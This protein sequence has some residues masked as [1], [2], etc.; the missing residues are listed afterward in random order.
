MT[1]PIP[2]GLDE[3][4]LTA[5]FQSGKA[6]I[7]AL[8]AVLESKGGF[9]VRPDR[10]AVR[11]IL[12]ADEGT[13][14]IH[15]HLEVRETRNKKHILLEYE[16]VTS[17]LEHEK[18]ELSVSQ[19]PSLVIPHIGLEGDLLTGL[20]SAVFTLQLD[21]WEPTVPLPFAASGILDALPGEPRISGLDFSF[22]TPVA[23]QSL[24]R[25]F[26][27]TYDEVKQMVVKFMVVTKLPIAEPISDGMLATAARH[28]PIFARKRE[29][30]DAA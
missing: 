10:R 7:D 29:H 28:F 4:T 19:W 22:G 14:A 26:V 5:R 13:P 17:A 18:A 23:G 9:S 6:S 3:V 12:R 21:Q 30:A 15:G 2:E 1:V 25:A 11:G 20:T 27:S 16:I 24:R 8:V